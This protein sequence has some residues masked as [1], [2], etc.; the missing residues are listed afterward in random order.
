[1]LGPYAETY[2]T[3]EPGHL[4]LWAGF[5]LPLLLTAVIIGLGVLLFL[6]RGRVERLQDAGVSVPDMDHVYRTTMRR[7]DRVAVVVTSRT[8]RGS[9][10]LYLAVILSVMVISAVTAMSVGGVRVTEWRLWDTAVQA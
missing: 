3:G 7:I 1:L 6:A 2:P 10:P 4:T 5:E 9:L 8:Q